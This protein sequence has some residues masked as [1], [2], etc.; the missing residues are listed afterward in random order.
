[1]SSVPALNFG[2]YVMVYVFVRYNGVFQYE[3][4]VVGG[5]LARPFFP[6]KSANSSLDV[7]LQVL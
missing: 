3:M 1:M 4:L 2:L 7:A 6:V 5:P